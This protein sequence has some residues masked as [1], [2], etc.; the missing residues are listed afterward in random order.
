LKAGSIIDCATD[1][2]AIGAALQRATS[3]EFQAEIAAVV[4]L[5]GACDA[6]AQIHALLKQLDLTRHGA[7][8]FH[9]VA[10]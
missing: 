10:F 1:A 6:S 4:S 8:R 5:Y 2:S 7:K 9:D 3:R